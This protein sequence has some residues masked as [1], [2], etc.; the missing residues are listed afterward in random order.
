M[1]KGFILSRKLILSRCFAKVLCLVIFAPPKFIGQEKSPILKIL[2]D[3]KT[4]VIVPNEFA[5]LIF[6]LG[7][8]PLVE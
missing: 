6:G 8:A 5:N 3:F 2:Y 7:N 4:E 1:P